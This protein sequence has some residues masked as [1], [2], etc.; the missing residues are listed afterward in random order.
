MNLE[1]RLYSM[2]GRAIS[3]KPIC[4][5]FHGC[6]YYSLADLIRLVLDRYARRFGNVGPQQARALH[7]RLAHKYASD[8]TNTLRETLHNPGHRVFHVSS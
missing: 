6:L 8:H 7:E 4:Y 5:E 1:Q 3:G 2:H